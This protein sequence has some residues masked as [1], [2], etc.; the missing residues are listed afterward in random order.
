MIKDTIVQFV[1]FITNL[2]LEEFEPEWERYAEKLMNKKA[3]PLLLQHVTETK[4][5]Y[6]YISKHEWPERDFNFNFINDRPSKYFPEN[7]VKIVQAGG[8]IPMLGKRKR[9]AENADIMLVA[10]ISHNE[11]DID[12]YRQLPFYNSLNIFQAYYESCSYGYVLEFCVP[13]IHADELL[14]QLNHRHGVE[15]G[16][17]RECLVPHL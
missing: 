16:I 14:V 6:R 7:K 10:L 1:C 5:K 2:E 3:K 11:N 12:F 4:S 15:A 17:Y 8:Y 9:P 13:E